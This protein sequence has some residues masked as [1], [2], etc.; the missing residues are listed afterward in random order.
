M[1]AGLCTSIAVSNAQPIADARQVD[2]RLR[3]MEDLA[4]QLG[5]HLIA[6]ATDQVAPAVNRGDSGNGRTRP[7]SFNGLAGPAMI[8]AQVDKSHSIDHC[9]R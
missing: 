9:R 3:E 2:G 7:A 1:D 6:L 4:H 8:Q 5:R